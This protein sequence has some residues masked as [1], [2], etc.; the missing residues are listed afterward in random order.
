MLRLKSASEPSQKVS[1]Q[2][3]FL[4]GGGGGIRTHEGVAPLPGFE[5]GA[6]N[7][8]ATPPRRHL[9]TFP[10]FLLFST[11]VCYTLA[12]MLG[13]D[14]VVCEDCKVRIGELVAR[15]VVPSVVNELL[16]KPR[17][18]VTAALPLRHDDGTVR[19]YNAFRVLYSDARG[20]GKGGIRFHPDVTEEEVKVLAFL[21]A[22]KCA[23]VD[24]PFGGAKGG[25]SVDPTKLSKGELERLSRAY[26]RAMLP[27]L[28]S[29]TDIPAPD[30][31]TNEEV[32]GWMVD[33]YALLTG[34]YDPST[35]T[36]KPLEIGGSRGR[37][38]ATGWGGAFVLQTYFA[39]AH[40]RSLEGVRVA[41]QGFGNVGAHL[42]HK[43]S[44]LGA[45]VVAV[46]D[47]SCAIYN[48]DGLD[49]PALLAAKKE[50]NTL[51]CVADAHARRIEHQELF[52]LP[53]DVLAPAALA[54]QVH[55]GNAQDV[56]ASVVLEMANDPVTPEAD[57]ILAQKGVV[58]IPDILANAGGVV[59]SYFEWIQNHENRYWSFEEVMRAL[60]EKMT[61]V[62]RDLLARCAGE[63]QPCPLRAIAYEL[64]IERILSAERA[65]GHIS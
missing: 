2:R 4:M 24:V 37:R 19:L 27:V 1:Q 32:M 56:Q 42:V 47:A 35:F 49:V 9:T 61:A 34:R 28:G 11:L 46:S 30:V 33:E 26:V 3:H 65:R 59:V 21:M 20:P 63:K 55:S 13:I 53:V 58:V 16:A 39:E 54:H 45:K 41:V 57:Q 5:P 23:L 22:L 36:G 43:L 40:Q 15:G 7:H 31:N 10:A 60:E 25:V 8:S 18:V 48:P 52:H 62:T 51:S 14:R 12:A 50:H 44:A 38:E 17:R 64:A 29:R 6:F